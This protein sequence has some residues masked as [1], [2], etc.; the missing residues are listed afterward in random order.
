[1]K[2]KLYI[3]AGGGGDALT[4]LALTDRLNQ[5]EVVYASFSWDRK[6]YDPDV[7]PRGIGDFENVKVVGTYNAVIYPNSHLRNKKAISSLQLIAK[8]YNREFYLLD[9]N[10]G[11]VGLKKQI[12]EIISLHN[13][14]CVY[15][16]DVGGDILA[17]GDESNLKS[18]LAD[19]GVLAAC[20]NLGV[21]TRVLV[22]GC[23][24]DGELTVDEL[25]EIITLFRDCAKR[26][27]E[28]DNL[29]QYLEAF[30]WLPSEASALF[31]LSCMGFKGTCEIRQD[32]YRIELDEFSSNVYDID[33]NEVYHHSMIADK[34]SSM[35]TLNAVEQVVLEITGKSE[36]EIERRKL[37]N[38]SQW[39]ARR[40]ND[41]L[42]GEL[43][44]ISK[45]KKAEGVQYLTQRRICEL[46]KLKGPE[47]KHFVQFLQEHYWDRFAIAIWR[48]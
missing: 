10:G 25:K 7:G 27:L 47:R 9:Y 29:P 34:I 28:V 14:D 6:I 30:S 46:L 21:R 11:T 1:M 17:V 5:D 26:Q 38:I 4:T 16:V 2:N 41:I 3:A 42:L 48:V 19:A 32:G 43:L 20:N 18:P 8:A 45:R 33:Y 36:L 24:L 35:E 31:L 23:G 37:T 15:I 13:I 40:D 12:L 22:A 44:E 39:Y